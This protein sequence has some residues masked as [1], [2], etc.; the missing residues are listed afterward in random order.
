MAQKGIIRDIF[1]VIV[2]YNKRVDDVLR[3]V[4]PFSC[5]LGDVFVYDNS[6]RQQSITTQNIIYIHNPEN[7]GVSAAYNAAYEIATERRKKWLLLLDHDTICTTE[8]LDELER[9]ITQHPDTSVFVPRLCAN[10]NVVSPF[11]WMA[12]RGWKINVNKNVYPLNR[13]RFA[14][15][16][17]LVSCTAFGRICGYSEKI[18]LDFADIAFGE[19]LL[20][21]TDHFVVVN[22]E[23]QHDFSATQTQQSKTALAR[24][25]MFC[26]DAHAMQDEFGNGL[27]LRINT[28]LRA[29]KLTLRHR[30]LSFLKT[31]LST[32]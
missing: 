16:G 10:G 22:A 3:S 7:G 13:Y 31:A 9:Q 12:G 18:K 4:L 28:L 1:F 23:L 5:E 19:R 27:V 14:N 2:I 11:R 8:Y 17:A 25:K 21:I 26:T 30:N 15:S 20:S 32:A 29:C 24:F 6:P